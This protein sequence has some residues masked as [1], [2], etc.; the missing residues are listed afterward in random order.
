MFGDIY[1]V[2]NKE[3]EGKR[4]RM[5]CRKIRK[6]KHKE[7]DEGAKRVVLGKH[8]VQHIAATAGM[9]EKRTQQ[10]AQNDTG[11]ANMIQRTTGAMN[12]RIRAVEPERIRQR[13]GGD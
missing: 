7:R 12:Q 11:Q 6:M 4:Y 3:R 9:K 8:N 10:P 5:C 13:P 1:A 2:E